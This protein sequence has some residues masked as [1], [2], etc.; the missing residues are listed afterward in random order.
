MPKH[1]ASS[2][3]AG[4]YPLEEPRESTGGRRTKPFLGSSRA[5]RGPARDADSISGGSWLLTNPIFMSVRE[6]PEGR[7]A[8][9][10]GVRSRTTS[11]DGRSATAF[12]HRLA[13]NGPFELQRPARCGWGPLADRGP[14]FGDRPDD[15]AVRGRAMPSKAACSL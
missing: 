11:P 1:I 10:L 14:F 2:V 15:H 5:F 4:A 6:P 8:P 12:D 3:K 9:D 13:F 7:E